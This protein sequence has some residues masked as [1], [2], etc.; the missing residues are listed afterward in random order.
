MRPS[1]YH[2]SIASRPVNLPEAVRQ[3]ISHW[4][5]WPPTLRERQLEQ[6]RIE[7]LVEEI[8]EAE[9]AKGGKAS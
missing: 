8:A 9:R 4:R 5:G 7:R 1:P 2:P 6:R 3:I